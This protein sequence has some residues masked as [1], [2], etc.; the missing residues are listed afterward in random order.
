VVHHTLKAPRP[1][2]VERTSNISSEE[3][4]TIDG[5]CDHGLLIASTALYSSD[6]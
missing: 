3:K 6:F 4:G 5:F 1:L 2:E